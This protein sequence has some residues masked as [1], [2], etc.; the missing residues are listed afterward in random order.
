MLRW[1]EEGRLLILLFWSPSLKKTVVVDRDG[2]S[3][4]IVRID[5]MKYLF[6]SAGMLLDRHRAVCTA[7]ALLPPGKSS[8]FNDVMS[9]YRGV[10]VCV[11]IVGISFSTSYFVTVHGLYTVK[12]LDS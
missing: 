7:Y 1:R 6:V 12:Y 3:L 2:R 5:L 4:E 10:C 9:M 11:S 8:F